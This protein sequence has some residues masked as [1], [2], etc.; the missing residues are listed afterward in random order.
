MSRAKKV[1]CETNEY[2][3]QT[4][5][6]NIRT[7]IVSLQSEVIIRYRKQCEEIK[8]TF[9]RNKQ[10]GLISPQTELKF[11]KRLFPW[12]DRLRSLFN[13]AIHYK[14][15]LY[16]QLGPK[17][18]SITLRDY[19]YEFFDKEIKPIWPKGWMSLEI[20]KQK[21]KWVKQIL[22]PEQ[23]SSQQSSLQT[24]QSTSQPI[25]HSSH[26]LAPNQSS[27]PIISLEKANKVQTPTQQTSEHKKPAFMEIFSRQSSEIVVNKDNIESIEQKLP[28]NT[29]IKSLSSSNNMPK[30]NDQMSEGLG[31]KFIPAVKEVKDNVNNSSIDLSTKARSSPKPLNT[32][33]VR[34]S[35]VNLKTSPN[36]TVVKSNSPSP[37]VSPLAMTSILQSSK[38]HEKISRESCLQK[39]IE[40]S[41]GDFPNSSANTQRNSKTSLLPQTSSPNTEMFIKGFNSTPNKDSKTEICIEIASSPEPYK[42]VQHQQQSHQQKHLLQQIQQQKLHQKAQQSQHKTVNKHLSTTTTTSTTNSPSNQHSF[43]RNSDMHK[44]KANVSNQS[45]MNSA[46]KQEMRQTAQTMDHLLLQSQIARNANRDT[47]ISITPIPQKSNESNS[48]SSLKHHSNQNSRYSNTASVIT[49]TSSPINLAANQQLLNL[50]M[51]SNLSPQ[52]LSSYNASTF[53]RL[54]GAQ[55]PQPF[56]PTSSSQNHSLYYPQFNTPSTT[57]T[58]THQTGGKFNLKQ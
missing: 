21:A 52:L 30:M 26:T 44:N 19:L 24:T 32:P 18:Q 33:N 2:N 53:H 23:Q 55:T 41:L 51:W 22:P 27:Q 40:Q 8:Q 58:T 16:E 6:A 35:P 15:N 29:T 36:I 47:S 45:S 42:K 49:S 28:S 39:V 13:D 34:L 4:A 25:A 12:N 3:L 43:H 17:N 38:Q 1:L 57:T 54:F 50:H 31:S 37:S 7:I 56:V 20:L 5:I 48:N 10:N 11:P 14:I 46:Q 9:E